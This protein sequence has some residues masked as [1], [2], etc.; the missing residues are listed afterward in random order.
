MRKTLD[1]AAA[2]NNV[3]SIAAQALTF[4]ELSEAFCAE[5]CDASD[6][7]LRKFKPVFGHLDA[8]SITS[9]QLVTVHQALIEG[10]YKPSTANRDLSTIG[11][12]YKWAITKRITPRG[13]KSPSLGVRRAAEGIRRVEVKAET[14]TALRSRAQAHPDRRF[15][16]FVALLI[17]TGARKSELLER[18]WG[19]VDQDNE[20]IV[21]P[22]T[23]NGMPRVLFYSK[24]TSALLKRIKPT[25]V[26]LK[27][28]IFAG[29]YG[30][31][32]NYR[33]SWRTLTKAVGVP[34]LHMHDVRH[35]AAARLLRSG[36][37]LGIA[38]QVLGHDAAVLARRY[39]HLETASLRNA[40]EQAW[41][42]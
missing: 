6:S 40:Q 19:E 21:A 9:E 32:V 14:L 15:G 27:L 38:A 16:L 28:L 4:E 11:S 35:A 22:T 41:A 17:D 31:P 5:R 12:M 23:K 39:G 10:G 7:R 42:A 29:R 30:N 34:D 18:T 20:H 33:T 13:F 26:D 37:T 8:W 1:L 2:M 25:N 24:I 3:V 36:V